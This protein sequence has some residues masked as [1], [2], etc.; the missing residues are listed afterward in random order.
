MGA[1][2]AIVVSFPLAVA[3]PAG[4]DAGSSNSTVTELAPRTGTDALSVQRLYRAFFLRAPDAG[5]LAYWQQK[6]AS[7]HSLAA[8]ASNFA[9][10]AEFRA[11]YGSL[12]DA[13]FVELVYRNVMSRTADVAGR[14]H[15]TN[16][17]RS[18]TLSRGGVMLSFSDSAEYKVRTGLVGDSGLNASAHQGRG[19]THLVISDHSGRNVSRVAPTLPE[20]K[21]YV[22][23]TYPVETNGQP[24]TTALPLH[25][26]GTYRAGSTVHCGS[27][28]GA[29][30]HAC[31]G[32]PMMDQVSG[33]NWA[34]I[35]NHPD[36][37]GL[38]L[39]HL[40]GDPQ[41]AGRVATDRI[42]YSGASMGGISGLLFAGEREH[43]PR[44]R[45]VMSWVGFA[46]FALPEIGAPS[47][48]R[49]SPAVL[50]VNAHDDPDIPYELARRTVNHA[51]PGRVEL[52]TIRTGGHSPDCPA[53]GRYASEWLRHHMFG[54]PVP[55]KNILTGC[56]TPGVLPGGTTGYGLANGFIR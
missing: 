49:P 52:V 16:A 32:F 25:V 39:D 24:R 13:A 33:I 56:A 15:W 17:L 2:L 41:L 43:D 9:G 42:V 45:A 7:G 37:I 40:I 26:E 48:W 4:A 31:V 36:D 10:S 21:I 6:V 30:I 5:G 23:V 3:N 19:Q 18:G 54:S 8:V 44:I 38:V 20:R 47:T 53:A 27:Q 50:M 11:R 12:D 34:D 1:F 22:R 28:P 51:G 55:A 29:F 35:A 46:T 14:N